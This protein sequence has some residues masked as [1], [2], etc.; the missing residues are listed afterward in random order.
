MVNLVKALLVILF[1]E[2]LLYLYLTLIIGATINYQEG[3]VLLTLPL[4][5]MWLPL[6]L[7]L[8]IQ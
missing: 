3:L 5:S 6:T 2:L 7:V 4:G 1:F 8:E